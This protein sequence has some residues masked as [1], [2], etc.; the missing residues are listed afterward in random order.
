[1]EQKEQDL[2]FMERVAE[3]YLHPGTA[4][5]GSLR[6]VAQKFG[7]TRTTV[8]KILI[9]L[10]AMES[11]LPEEALALQQTGHSVSEIAEKLGLSVA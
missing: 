11:P 8:R 7:I 1:M 10:G 2:E 4:L 5:S 9:T 3:A 6:A